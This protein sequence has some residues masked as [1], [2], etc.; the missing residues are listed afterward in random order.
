M[1]TDA[2]PSW[3]GLVGPPGAHRADW[4]VEVLG[5]LLDREEVA[6]TSEYGLAILA[7]HIQH[8]TSS[9]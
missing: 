1:A 9:S 4:D 8:S 7:V 6:I 3:P 2:N 5:D